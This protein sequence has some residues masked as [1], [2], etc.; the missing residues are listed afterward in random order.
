MK[1]ILIADS[2]HPLLMQGFDERQ[3]PYSY[4]PDITKAEAEKQ[5]EEFSGLIIRSKFEVDKTFIDQ[6]IFLN[7]IAR[8]GSGM[9]NIDQEYAISKGIRCINAPEGLCD[10]VAEH[11]VGMLLSL[12]NNLCESNA[13]IKQGAWNREVFRG[14][15]LMGLTVGIIGYGHTGSAMARKLGG[16]G[17]TVLAYDKYKSGFGNIHVVESSLDDLFRHSDVISLHIPQNSETFYWFNSEL[18]ANFKKP[19]WFINTSRGKIVVTKDLVNA[20]KTGKIKGVCLDVLE[21]ENPASFGEFEKE[22]FNYLSNSKH[23]ILTPHIAGW[24]H[25][26]YRR[27]SEVLLAKILG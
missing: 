24:T 18:I 26:S 2:M 1:P 4:L 20:L 9:E 8:A 17:C 11:A 6:A 15:E 13:R 23:A 10:A 19:I 21:N 7:M 16:F 14:N 3:I 22:W 5:I 27:I 25:E 12:L